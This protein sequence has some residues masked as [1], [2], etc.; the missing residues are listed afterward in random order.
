[1]QS[2][3]RTLL[4]SM[5]RGYRGVS[6]KNALGY[7]LDIA[8]GAKEFERKVR[9]VIRGLTVFFCNLEFLNISK[10]GVFTY[11]YF[12]HKLLRWLVPFFLISAMCSNLALAQKGWFYTI[13]LLVQFA[14]Y[15]IGILGA[16]GRVV[17]NRSLLKI[18]MYFLTVNY[19]ILVAW[20]RYL[21]GQRIVMWKPSE[22]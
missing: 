1:M 15:G 20:K 7:Y 17:F 8:D 14:F 16:T 3:F 18:P 22:R 19:A 5:K 21:T 10:Y 4:S 11:Q 12:C 6:D 9:T 2:D 13:A